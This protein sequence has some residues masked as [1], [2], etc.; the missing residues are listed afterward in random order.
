MSN[1][2]YD[3]T[4]GIADVLN[5]YL[6]NK[7]KERIAHTKANKPELKVVDGVMYQYNPRDGS[8]NP[9]SGQ[10]DTWYNKA[11]DATSKAL[12]IYTG[13][14]EALSTRGAFLDVS[15][16]LNSTDYPIKNKSNYEEFKKNTL[17]NYR[18]TAEFD[19][20]G[21]YIGIRNANSDEFSAEWFDNKFGKIEY[22]DFE[23]PT[24]PDDPNSPTTT[25]SR[26]VGATGRLRTI[27]ESG[28][29]PGV[30]QSFITNEVN[31]AMGIQRRT[32]RRDNIKSSQAQ[33]SALT[34][35]K[36]QVLGASEKIKKADIV[37]IL[38]AKDLVLQ[39]KMSPQV[40]NFIAKET[41]YYSILYPGRDIIDP[42]S[43]YRY[44]TQRTIPDPDDPTKTIEDPSAFNAGFM[45]FFHNTVLPDIKKFSEQQFL[46]KDFLE[47]IQKS[48]KDYFGKENMYTITG[49]HKIMDAFNQISTRHYGETAV[50][51]EDYPLILSAPRWDNKSSLDAILG[52]PITDLGNN[53]QY[54]INNPVTD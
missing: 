24:N 10:S 23:V 44:Q 12:N 2:G 53:L 4:T 9:V 17:K 35:A 25:I 16:A 39:G 22:K 26:A 40:K 45:N 54:L 32:N 3:L 52:G 36:N 15:N 21:K 31:K 14:T 7:S 28:G 49:L 8:V 6:D 34:Y 37:A 5:S 50:D 30:H 20:V 13:D 47:K 51:L 29:N 46:D 19:I 27:I 43:V 41:N 33:Q 1:G 48:E 38:H 18:E 11:Q 42:E